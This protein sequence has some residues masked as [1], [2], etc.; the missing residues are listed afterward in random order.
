MNE[1]F[2]GAAV[3]VLDNWNAVDLNEAKKHHYERGPV[4][5]EQSLI[6]GHVLFGKVKLPAALPANLK[7]IGR[8]QER[9][10]SPILSKDRPKYIGSWNATAM[11]M[12]A[13]FAQPALAKTMMEAEFMLP[14]GGP[15]YA[16]LSLLHRAHILSKPP[17]GN[18]LDDESFQPGSIYLNNSLMVD[19]RKGMADLSLVDLHSGLYMLGT[20]F[21]MSKNWF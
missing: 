3:G 13:L 12:V 16:A 2:V 21:P 14:P 6:G 9:W 15:I 11:F 20:R 1:N 5:I 10:L 4:P 8:A 7:H 19:I 17:E 18:E